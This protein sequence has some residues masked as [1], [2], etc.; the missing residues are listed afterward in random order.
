MKFYNYINE[1]KNNI[2][3]I[4]SGRFQPFHQNHYL[5]YKDLLKEFGNSNCYIATSNKTEPKKSPFNFNEK[6][7]IITALFDVPKNKVIQIKNPY[8]PEEILKKYPENYS[9]V[10]AV[11]GKDADRLTHGKYFE[12]YKKGME[13]EGYKNKGYCWI[14]PNKMTKYKGQMISGT[15]VRD[16][17]KTVGNKEAKDFFMTLFGNWNESIFN[18]IIKKLGA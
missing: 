17:F 3:A 9:Y 18:L 13:L 15:L 16:T 6:K 10:T 11:G 4:Y 14:I 1:D 12:V 5:V 2:V 8:S 7:K